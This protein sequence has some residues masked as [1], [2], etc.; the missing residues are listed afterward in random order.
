M[1]VQTLCARLVVAIKSLV[2]LAVRVSQQYMH[3]GVCSCLDKVSISVV[4][5]KCIVV[6]A[7]TI[8][9]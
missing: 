9:F 2:T 1:C 4:G 7:Y 5:S 6:A 8:Q 3:Y